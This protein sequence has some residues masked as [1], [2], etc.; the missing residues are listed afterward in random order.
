MNISKNQFEILSYIEREGGRKITQRE[1]ADRT[2]LSLGLANRTLGE[3]EELGLVSFNPKKEIQVTKN[4]L[5]ALDIRS[6]P[7]WKLEGFEGADLYV[8]AGIPEKDGFFLGKKQ[9]LEAEL[10]EENIEK[11]TAF[12]AGLEKILR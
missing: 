1:L 12:L 4:G 11:T 8:A 5:E 2:R 7:D 6:K 10:S 9:L 3:L